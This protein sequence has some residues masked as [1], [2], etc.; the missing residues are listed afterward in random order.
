[1]F[2]SHGSCAYLHYARFGVEEHGAAVVQSPCPRRLRDTLPSESRLYRLNIPLA[3]VEALAC[4]REHYG[5]SGDLRINAVSACSELHHLPDEHRDS[6]I[7]ES[8]RSSGSVGSLGAVRKHDMR[9]TSDARNAVQQ[10]S[11]DLQKTYDLRR[12]EINSL[13]RGAK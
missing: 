11:A 8:H 13:K 6:G 12:A 7:R 2:V 4:R 5:S 9:K 3:D 10:A 1:M